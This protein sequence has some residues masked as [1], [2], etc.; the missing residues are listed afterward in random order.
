MLLPNDLT[1][2]LRSLSLIFFSVL[3]S[4]ATAAVMTDFGAAPCGVWPVFLV[5]VSVGIFLDG[6]IERRLG[7]KR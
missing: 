1:F 6:L 2:C 5:S 3:A 7:P 4:L